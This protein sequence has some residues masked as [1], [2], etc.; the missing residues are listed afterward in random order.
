MLRGGVTRTRDL[1]LIFQQR[2]KRL[3][4][5]PPLGWVATQGGD[6]STVLQ[7]VLE[8]VRRS[9]GLSDTCAVS[10]ALERKTARLR[11]TFEG[12]VLKELIRRDKRFRAQ[13]R[14]SLVPSLKDTP[15]QD[16]AQPVRRKRLVNNRI[17][18]PYQNY[19]EEA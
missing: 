18:L 7:E 6:S 12:F 8:F 11:A 17:N 16:D 5:I 9:E 3:D 19:E 13:A 4:S 14:V 1:F 2:E 10:H 15:S